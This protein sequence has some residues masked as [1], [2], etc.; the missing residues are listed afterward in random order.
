[1]L[2]LSLGGKLRLAAAKIKCFIAA[3][4]CG[5][6]QCCG[7]Q[8]YPPD[9]EGECC[10]GVWHVGT[11]GCPDGQIY[12]RW[13]ANDECCGC[14]PVQVFDPR[15]QAM[16]NTEDVVADLCC[17][18][19]PAAELP[20]AL[21]PFDQ[22]GNDVGC[23]SR[24]CVDGVCTEVRTSDCAGQVLPGCCD[25]GCPKDCCSEDDDGVVQ[26][27][28]VDE[29]FCTAPKVLADP[30]CA[31]GCLGQCCIDDEDGVPQPHGM[32]TQEACAAMDGNWQGLGVEECS[33]CKCRDPFTCDCCETKTSTAAGLVFT[34][35]RSKRQPPFADTFRVTVNGKTDST[36]LVHGIPVPAGC[37]FNIEFVLCWDEF[38]IEPVPCDTN[39][40]SLAVTVCWFEEHT[41]T[42]ELSFSGCDGLTV[43]LGDCE[44]D[45]V[46][47]L[48]YRQGDSRVSDAQIYTRADAELWVQSGTIEFTGNITA[49]A[50]T[51]GGAPCAASP[52]VLKLTGG[53]GKISGAIEDIPGTGYVEVHRTYHSDDD[54]EIHGGTWFLSGANSF[55][56]QLKV[57]D[58]TLVIGADVPSNSV[59]SPF[60]KSTTLLPV[61]GDTTNSPHAVAAALLLDDDVT[62]SRGMSVAAAGTYSQQVI[63]GGYG[64]GSSAFDTGT[65]TLGRDVTLRAA[66]GGTVTF[67]NAWAIDGVTPTFTI[68]M[69]SNSGT[70][71]LNQG[72]PADSPVIVQNCTAEM[73]AD[74]VISS[75]PV[76]VGS[77]VGSAT[78][79]LGGFSQNLPTLEFAGT[80][81][82][83]S[84][85]TLHMG[86][87]GTSEIT[88]TG[89]G[90]EISTNVVLDLSTAVTVNSGASLTVSGVVSGTNGITVD[91]GGTLTLSAANTYSGTTT[92]DGGTAKA[93]NAAAFGTGGI[94]VNAGG[95]LDKNGYTLANSITNNGGTVIP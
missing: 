16:V 13:G 77:A 57:F 19:I 2:L 88:T 51:Q 23:F 45:C 60:G 80:S 59:D 48:V 4:T 76:T 68:G 49:I 86:Y 3:A 41:P 32:M 40:K 12:L 78:L 36:I 44:Y 58:G 30:D 35:P 5:G 47:T 93:G 6:G 9:A 92:I 70:V 21:L 72:L 82:T 75:S 84:N 39:F 28:T 18:C 81:S 94:V 87:G 83:V 26:C 85:G 11:G 50:Q 64:S 66:N 25:P 22:F 15:V 34:Q 65:V 37:D 1:M 90:H 91:G 20:A 17:G 54:G 43:N 27:S 33:T 14:L 8:Y 10:G 61:L 63:L 55:V 24:C 53:T 7:G 79:D 42:E 46:T 71:V 95:T 56:G 74:D 29:V 67:S 52:R 62:V 31:T 89:T 38:F 73:G 69:A